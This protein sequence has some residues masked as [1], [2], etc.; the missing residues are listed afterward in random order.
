MNCTLHR[1]RISHAAD[2]R[3]AAPRPTQTHLAACAACR[4][5]ADFCTRLPRVLAAGVP[6]V[7]DRFDLSL[8]RQRI[9]ARTAFA[10]ESAKPSGN[11]TPV[12]PSLA[13]FMEFFSHPW[14]PALATCALACLLLAGGLVRQH[15]EREQQRTTLAA[16]Q[17]VRLACDNA[18]QQGPSAMAGLLTDATQRLAADASAAVDFISAALPPAA[19]PDHS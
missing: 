7:D 15:V 19:Q 16:L 11:T 9:L 14:K 3:R 17:A 8:L 12:F 5:Y 10:P 13:T 4:A 6:A 18:L 2:A 1:W